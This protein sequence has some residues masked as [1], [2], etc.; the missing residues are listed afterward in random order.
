M[1]VDEVPSEALQKG[2]M[3]GDCGLPLCTHY[4]AGTEWGT[5]AVGFAATFPVRGEGI[6]GC[7][8]L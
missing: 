8:L 1:A 3:V 6:S 2:G 5:S 7:R 4:T